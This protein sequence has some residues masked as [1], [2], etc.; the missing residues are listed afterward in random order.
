MPADSAINQLLEHQ[1][2]TANNRITSAS[3]VSAATAKTARPYPPAKAFP[4]SKYG[5]ATV[6]RRLPVSVLPAVDRLLAR[7]LAE[8][9]AGDPDIWE[10]R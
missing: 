6:M 1:L 5:E 4:R 7:R 2:T 10:S 3:A 9:D 8:A